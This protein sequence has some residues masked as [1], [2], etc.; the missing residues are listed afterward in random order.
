MGKLAHPKRI[1]ING[2]LKMILEWNAE[3]WM[4]KV[5]SRDQWMDVARRSIINKDLTEKD[6]ED[7]YFW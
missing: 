3:D 5:K 2:N 4:R 6:A 1:R 7:R